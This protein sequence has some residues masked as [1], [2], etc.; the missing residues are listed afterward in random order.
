MK[1]LKTNDDS[2]QAL[3]ST[4]VHE[5]KIYA[6]HQIVDMGEG[7]YAGEAVQRLA[8]FENIAQDIKASQEMVA[9]KLE[10]LRAEGKKNSVQFRELLVKKMNNAMI[11]SVFMA[12]GLE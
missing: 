1:D 11:L 4:F 3:R 9:A 10:Q 2:L 12:Y 7:V 5:G 8:A 6:T